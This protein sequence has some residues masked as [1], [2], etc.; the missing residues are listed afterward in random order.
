M[1]S[2]RE[3]GGH[4][5][6]EGAAESSVDCSSRQ[7]DVRTATVR[8]GIPEVPARAAAIRPALSQRCTRRPEPPALSAARLVAQRHAE[9]SSKNPDFARRLDVLRIE[10][11]V[12]RGGTEVE[13]FPAHGWIAAKPPRHPLAESITCG[14]W[15]ASDGGLYGFDSR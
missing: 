5:K 6:E 4:H 13:R 8:P 2:L 12:E 10:H 15:M 1:L 9:T 11:E 7:P 3:P 14:R